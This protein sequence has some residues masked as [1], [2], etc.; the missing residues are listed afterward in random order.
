MRDIFVVA[1]FTI[2]E[3]I[4]KKSFIISTLIILFMIILGFNIPR[5]I[6]TF[7]SS[8]SLTNVLIVDKDNIFEK[9]IKEDDLSDIGYKLTFTSE[10][11]ENAKQLIKDEKYDFALYFNSSLNNE[12]SVLYITDIFNETI[13]TLPTDLVDALN[14]YYKSI[15]IDKLN[16]TIEQSNKV[17]TYF[18]LSVDAINDDANG[19]V[20]TMLVICLVLFYAV[21]FCAYQVSL[22]VTTEKT[23]KIVETLVTSTTPKNIILGKTI[24]IGIVGLCQLLLIVVTAVSSAYTFL[25]KEIF[26]FLFSESGI[27]LYLGIMIFIYFILGYLLYS[28]LYALTGSTATKPEDIQSVNTPVIIVALISFYL[29]YFSLINPS[30][31]LNKFASIFP[32]SSA[33]CM[34]TR[35]MANLATP[36]DIIISLGILLLTIVIVAKV[37][38]KIYSNAILNY[39]S[40]I[41]IK[42]ILKNKNHK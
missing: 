4:R 40:K 39:G 15:Q 24:G 8:E 42:N 30:S 5:I 37:S 3:M 21:Y 18:S 34:P 1:K 10:E 20:F 23:S 26:N 32:T 25:S 12:I 9:S 14:N 17:N 38:I 27:S 28:L 31:Q 16:L 33:F 19:N 7:S 36:S 29:A 41:N 11:Y 22:S 13:D 6:K 35:I 2:K